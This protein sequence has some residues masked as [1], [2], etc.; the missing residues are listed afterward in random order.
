MDVTTTMVT[1]WNRVDGND[2][3][4]IP[5]GIF[6]DNVI[7]WWFIVHQFDKRVSVIK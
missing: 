2:V 3:H 1:R 5:K 4:G 7:T 6:R